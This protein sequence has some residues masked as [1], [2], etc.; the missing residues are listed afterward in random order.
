MEESIM[1]KES[2]H[3]KGM[4]VTQAYKILLSQAVPKPDA[5]EEQF[6]QARDLAVEALRVFDPEHPVPGGENFFHSDTGT[7]FLFKCM[8]SDELTYLRQFSDANTITSPVIKFPYGRYSSTPFQGYTHRMC[9]SITEIKE[10]KEVSSVIN[11]YTNNSSKDDLINRVK[12]FYL[13]GGLPNLRSFRLEGAFTPTQDEATSKL[14][15]DLFDDHLNVQIKEVPYK[16][17][18]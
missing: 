15:E 6:Y 11:I 12:L 1:K 10:G 14:I 7:V 17:L 2:N 3:S 16:N 8:T 18:S 13:R 4:T 5:D 9:V